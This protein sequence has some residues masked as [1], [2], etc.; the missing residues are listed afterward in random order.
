MFS[1]KSSQK[2]LIYLH[3]ILKNIY[4]ENRFENTVPECLLTPLLHYVDKLP[5]AGELCE[6][7]FICIRHIGK[8]ATYGDLLSNE[9]Q[10]LLFQEALKDRLNFLYNALVAFSSGREILPEVKDIPLVI[11]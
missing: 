5:I 7:Y 8:D 4:T 1:C 9:K 10:M 2:L 3:S 6:T 11:F